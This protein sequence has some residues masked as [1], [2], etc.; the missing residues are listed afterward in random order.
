[1]YQYKSKPGQLRL[2][3]FTCINYC[4]QTDTSAYFYI[5]GTAQIKN[6]IYTLI[7]FFLKTKTSFCTKSTIKSVPAALHA[8][9][10]TKGNAGGEGGAA[11]EERRK[12]EAE[13]KGKGALEFG[14]GAEA[15]TSPATE[16]G[17]TAGGE[18]GGRGSEAVAG[19]ESRLWG[20]GSCNGEPGEEG[21]P[22]SRRGGR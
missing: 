13:G 14:T 7:F 20:V 5:D 1:M 15:G 6:L 12:G 22:G 21:G 10:E 4:V 3:K 19:R 2:N 9:R 17:T 11:G 16:R 18:N 8:E